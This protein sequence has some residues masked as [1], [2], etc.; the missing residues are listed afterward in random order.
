MPKGFAPAPVITAL[1]SANFV[2]ALLHAIDAIVPFNGALL[3]RLHV[4]RKP[5]HVY[6]TVRAERRQVVVDQYLDSAYLLDPIY[7]G[8]VQ[9]L[10]D[11]VLRLRDVAPDHFRR[12][13]YFKHYYGNIDLAD[14]LAIL[15]RLPQQSALFISLGRLGGEPRF[16]TRE[17][18]A[19]RRELDVIAALVRKHFDRAA[20]VLP[21]PDIDS[22]IT[23]A[24]ESFG[25]GV[26]TAREREIATLILRGHSSASISEVTGTTV[27]T[28]KIHR[29]NLYRKLRISSQSELLARFLGA[30]VA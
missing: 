25:D 13:T 18:T 14:E 27:G 24:F 1:H 30:V 3:T 12:S 4:D 26:L 29:K 28:V 20:P 10:G 19:L 15:V 22:S 5:S 9:G 7:N 6:D 11:V 16:T 2:P 8:F 23:E 17:M 21:Q